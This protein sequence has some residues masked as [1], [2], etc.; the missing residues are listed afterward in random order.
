MDAEEV[1]L[2]T[3]AAKP[4]SPLCPPGNYWG[5]ARRLSRLR[6]ADGTYILLALDHGMSLGPLTGIEDF[7]ICSDHNL[8]AVFTGVVLNR[9]TVARALEPSSR[10]GVVLQ[11]FGSPSNEPDKRKVRLISPDEAIAIGPDA[12]AVELHLDRGHINSALREVTETIASCERL[13][14]PVLLMISARAAD[15][16]IESL[17]HALRIA[18]ELG[19]DLIKIGLPA[20]LL[21]DDGASMSSLL[22]AINLAPPVLLAG[23]PLGSDFLKVIRLSRK[24]GFQGICVGRNVFQA[25]DPSGCISEIGRAYSSNSGSQE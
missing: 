9:G 19:V 11:S 17:T 12:I 14:I 25:A 24:L 13:G 10:L 4:E 21:E 3:L 16:H 7:A 18:T 5:K 22:R 23:G 2:T 1:G 20:R 6:R 15:S 8:A